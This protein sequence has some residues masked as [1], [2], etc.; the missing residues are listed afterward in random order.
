MAKKVEKKE[1]NTS[2]YRFY[3]IVCISSLISHLLMDCHAEISKYQRHSKAVASTMIFH[4]WTRAR[5]IAWRC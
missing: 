5:G 2:D 3:I 1:V 4:K